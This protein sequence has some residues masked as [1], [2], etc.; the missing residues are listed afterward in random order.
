MDSSESSQTQ[1]QHFENSQNIKI[2]LQVCDA[3]AHLNFLKR[4]DDFGYHFYQE[5]YVNNAIRRYEKFWLPM[6]TKISDNPNNDVLY[7]PPLGK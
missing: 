1:K 7:N 5:D 6:I 4:I 2:S 3:I